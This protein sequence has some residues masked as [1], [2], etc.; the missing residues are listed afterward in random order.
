[1]NNEIDYSQSWEDPAVLS[2]ALSAGPE[3]RVLSITSGGDNSLALL[4]DGAGQVVSIDINPAQN[5]LLE[6]KRAAARALS[7][8]EYT[9]LVGVTSSSPR[10]ALFERIQADLS[11]ACRAWW[12]EHMEYVRIGVIHC[13][14]FERFTRFFAQ[15]VLPRIHSIR[16]IEQ[17]LDCHD[18]EEQWNFYNDRWNTR[19]WRLFFGIASSRVMLKSFAR[20]RGM[21]TFATR[22]MAGLY[23]GRFERLLRRTPT[24]GNYF[25]HYSLRGT[26]G[27]ALPPYLTEAG[28]A[29][30]RALPESA[31]AFVADDILHYLHTEPDNAFSGF[32][33]SD[34]FEAL[35]PH[36][37][38]A[39]WNE[40][41]RTAKPGARV[42]YWT[43]LVE[44][45]YPPGLSA[46]V[47][48]DQRA[49][50][51]LRARDRV[52]FYEGV[53]AHTI[54]T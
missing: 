34:I 1:M 23:R 9:E 54:C 18:V 49:V 25:L 46:Q 17:F 51:Q 28:Y 38:E 13:G 40:I 32:N 50:D 12:M 15:R 10:D 45:P 35:S 11:P 24:R 7:Y 27:G 26:Y 41:I 37:H 39:L 6:F 20:Q 33:L 21:F 19:L 29:R 5:Y 3:D 2:T 30:L 44:R 52:F 14:R 47:S 8:A 53:Y 43:N 22:D 36:Q 4:I 16:T 42:T 48:T 31:L